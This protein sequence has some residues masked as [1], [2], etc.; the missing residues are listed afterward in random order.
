MARAGLKST[1]AA[2]SG[3]KS[4]KSSGKSTVEGSWFV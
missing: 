1:C 2:E 4:S 3:A